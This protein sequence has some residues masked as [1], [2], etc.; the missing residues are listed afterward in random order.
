MISISVPVVPVVPV[1]NIP[2][3]KCLFFF[4]SVPVVPVFQ[5]LT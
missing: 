5:V 4:F 1:K 2:F 3:P